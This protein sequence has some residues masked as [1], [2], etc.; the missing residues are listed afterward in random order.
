MP[1][2]WHS[3]QEGSIAINMCVAKCFSIESPVGLMACFYPDN[4]LLSWMEAC[5]GSHGWLDEIKSEMAYTIHSRANTLG[6]AK[7][8]IDKFEQCGTYALMK[9]TCNCS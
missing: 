6:N 8:R 4:R 3:S 5:C 9:T 1:R 7:P 2:G